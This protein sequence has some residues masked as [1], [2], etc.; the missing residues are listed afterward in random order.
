MTSIS[1]CISV[2][3]EHQEL[4]KLL[5]QLVS[6]IDN[7]DE[8]VILVD[9]DKVTP[10][11][12]WVINKYKD[13][14]HPQLIGASLNK[15]FAAFKNNF[16]D[17][18]CKDFII[19]IDADELLSDDVLTDLKFIIE[20]NPTVDLYWVSR[21]NFVEGITSDHI[22][23]WGWRLDDKNRI[24]YPDLQARIFRNNKQIKWE[25]PVHEVIIGHKEFV[26]LP[27]NYYLIHNKT[28]ERQ[29]KQNSLYNTI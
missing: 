4:D 1:Y 22:Q 26:V 2:C 14:I 16:I 25:K 28:I 7:E 27:Q 5:G 29:E 24:N 15:N 3:N 18:A 13:L 10:E 19:Q 6:Y 17:K 21:E 23:K 12:T 8:V 9:Q 11:V 20:A